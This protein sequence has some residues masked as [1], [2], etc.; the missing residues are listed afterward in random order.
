MRNTALVHFFEKFS[1]LSFTLP[2]LPYPF[3]MQGAEKKQEMWAEM[4]QFLHHINLCVTMTLMSVGLG[5]PPIFSYLG[6]HAT[7]SKLIK[8]WWNKSLRGYLN[9]K[10]GVRSGLEI[11]CCF[12]IMN[13]FLKTQNS[14]IYEAAAPGGQMLPPPAFDSPSQQFFDSAM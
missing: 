9:I 12:D 3:E 5:P 10:G 14:S 2:L 6:I 8:S 13:F 7:S 11:I 4:C 1:P